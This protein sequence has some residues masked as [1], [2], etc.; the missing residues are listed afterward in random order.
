LLFGYVLGQQSMNTS[1]SPEKEKELADKLGTL[2]VYKDK[3][4]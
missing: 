2:N 3:E 4:D 1:L